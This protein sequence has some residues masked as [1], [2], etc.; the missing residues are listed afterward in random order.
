MAGYVHGGSEINVKRRRVCK[1]VH[2]FLLF[3][4]SIVTRLHTRLPSVV[5]TADVFVPQV[6]STAM[7]QAVQLLV[8][9]R[10]NLHTAV[11]LVHGIA[12][13]GVGDGCMQVWAADV[14]KRRPIMHHRVFLSAGSSGP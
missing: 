10:V 7:S 2:Y 4:E 8:Q 5:A 9:L 12:D 6:A 11:I 13:D 1:A 14:S 3:A